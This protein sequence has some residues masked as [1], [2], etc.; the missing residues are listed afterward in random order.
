[1]PT[2]SPTISESARLVSS[3]IRCAA[4]SVSFITC[5]RGRGF[6]LD[7]GVGEAGVM[8]VMWSI[9]K[10][11]QCRLFSREQANASPHIEDEARLVG[12][13]VRR[14]RRLPDQIDVDQADAGNAGD[15]VL[16]HR[17]Q[18]PRRR[19]V[20]RRQRH[21]DVH[22]AVVLDVDLVDQTK[23]IDVSRNFRIEHGLQRGD[24][25]AAEPLGLLR[26]QRR[27]GLHVAGFDFGG[28]AHENNSR[29]LISA[30]ARWS[31]SS[32][33]LYIPNEARHVA[34]TLNRS[35]SGI[36]QWVPARTATP[37]RSITVA[38]SCACAP[39]SSNEITGPLSL[40]VPIS[41]SELI[42][43]SRSCA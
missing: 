9:P 8:S 26:R 19:A 23:L 25:F 14:P 24:D 32:R 36:T 22:G 28:V 41:R 6:G 42:S 43:R 12:H 30:C 1:M 27:I 34:V 18:F 5:G 39:S 17:R 3:V 11:N 33:V 16:H 15:R 13:P 4:A 21:L 29:A 35:K 20:W 31:T 10:A 7:T 2:R 38:T 37:C 40:A